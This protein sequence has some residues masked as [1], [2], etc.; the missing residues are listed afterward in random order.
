M[1]WGRRRVG[2]AAG[3]LGL[4]LSG[5][6]L[7]AALR[8]VPDDAQPRTLPAEE[9]A[10]GTAPPVATT[11]RTVELVVYLV[12]ADHLA[13]V[14]RRVAERSPEA[15][16]AELE[17]G[18]TAAESEAGLRSALVP[19]TSLGVVR[20]SGDLI[21]VDLSRELTEA[22]PGEQVLA[23][24]QVVWTVTS[25]GGVTRVSFTLQG[26]PID[27]PGADGKLRAVPLRRADFASLR[28]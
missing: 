23:V 5:A 9:D 25:T 21:V 11:A 26:R 28:A 16:L 3:A 1:S 13:P 4:L 2:I 14:A 22:E 17:S 7:V 18:P 27:A 20:Q 8:G 6:L 15:A 24:A 19:G 12:R 10:A